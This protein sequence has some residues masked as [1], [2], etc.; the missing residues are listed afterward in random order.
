MSP[1]LIGAAKAD[2]QQ[3][4]SRT[5][6]AWA[7]PS[8]SW[9]PHYTH[10]ISCSLYFTVVFLTQSE[11]VF[12]W[13][14]HTHLHFPPAGP[15]SRHNKRSEDFRLHVIYIF[16][17][18]FFS[19]TRGLTP[20]LHLCFAAVCSNRWNSMGTTMR[21]LVLISAQF[22]QKLSRRSS[23]RERECSWILYYPYER[24]AVDYYI[25]DKTKWD[26][27]GTRKRLRGVSALRVIHLTEIFI[28]TKKWSRCFCVKVL[29]LSAEPTLALW[30]TPNMDGL[31]VFNSCPWE[32]TKKYPS[33]CPWENR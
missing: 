15:L 6:P 20:Y 3:R 8:E 32:N 12:N 11:A 31:V 5:L 14:A 29:P 16:L 2:D 10:G 19:F 13:H 22:E 21:H 24:H 28:E 4:P 23:M 26:M 30:P 27:Y 33:S 9:W 18:R 7:K 1:S 17:T 25:I